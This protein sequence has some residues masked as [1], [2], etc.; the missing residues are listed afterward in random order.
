MMKTVRSVLQQVKN[1]DNEYEVTLPYNT[2]DEVLESLESGKTLR[3]VNIEIND[4]QE[5]LL[6]DLGTI[7]YSLSGLIDD[8]L[9]LNQLYRENFKTNENINITTGVYTQGCV[10][11]VEN[12]GIDFRLRTPVTLNMK[13]S[14]FKLKH[15]INIKNSP[16]FS[17][18][19][20]FNALDAQPHWFSIN[21]ALTSGSFFEIPEF[22]KEDSKPYA[23]NIRI[24]ANCNNNSSIEISD[25][26]VLYI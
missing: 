25:L 2:M 10:K 15:F 24:K 26:M 16:V 17:C 5:G 18:E 8:R 9:Q 22:V 12:Q 21:N 1:A 6:D 13:P 4:K 11:S 7:M 14:K 23:M 19:I 20:T 3:Q